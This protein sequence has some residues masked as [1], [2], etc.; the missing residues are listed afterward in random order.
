[1][2][3][4]VGR[5]I[6]AIFTHARTAILLWLVNIALAMVAFLPIWWWWSRT[7]MLP[8]TDPLLERFH[9]GIFRDLLIDGGGIRHC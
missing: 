1:M 5:G 9:V 2:T 3:T 4:S 8:E 7:V 6:R